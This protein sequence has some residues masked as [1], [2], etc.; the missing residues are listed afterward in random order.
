MKG[1]SGQQSVFRGRGVGELRWIPDQ[2][3]MTMGCGVWRF[4]KRQKHKD[5][6]PA[7]AGM[8]RIGEVN[9]K[10]AGGERE[11]NL[12]LIPMYRDGSFPEHF[13]SPCLSV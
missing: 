4:A 11:S 7:C 9:D 6:I 5:W 10:M 2:S 12:L 1:E 13:S 3:G 8:D